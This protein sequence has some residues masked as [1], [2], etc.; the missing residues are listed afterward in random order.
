MSWHVLADSPLLG[1]VIGLACL[2]CVVVAAAG[3]YGSNNSEIPTLPASYGFPDMIVAMA[4]DRHDDKCWFSNYGDTVDLAAP[5]MRVQSTG[6]YYINPRYP[7]HSGTS[8]AAAYLSGAAALLL[9]IDH[10]TPHE[11]HDHLNASADRFRTLQGLCRS[12]GRLNLRRAVCGPIR[13]VAPVGGHPLQH[14]TQLTVQ[15]ASEYAPSIVQNVQISFINKANGNILGQFGGVAIG[16]GHQ[17]VTVPS[18]V[19]AQAFVRVRSVE[20]NL[21]EDS[22]VFAIV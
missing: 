17:Q 16:L 21:Y 18:Q 13:I 3:N 6:L 4:S 12:N 14:G 9:A 22:A 20:K 2:Q 15:W 1:L 11:I 10:W 8:V 5:G 7:D 19:T